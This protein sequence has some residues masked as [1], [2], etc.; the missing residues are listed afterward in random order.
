MKAAPPF[1][2][3]T[4]MLVED[5]VTNNLV[6]WNDCGTAFIVWRPAEFAR[7]LLPTLFKH[8]NFSSFV[9][10]LNTYFD[11]LELHFDSLKFELVNIDKRDETNSSSNSAKL[12]GFRKVA[13]SRWE[14]S[15]E[16]F[17]KGERNQ[18]CN[19]RRR[20]SFS[21]KPRPNT[22]AQSTHEPKTQSSVDRSTSSTSS[23]SGFTTLAD[24]NKRLKQEN[25]VLRNELEIMKRKSK[26][27]FDL[28]A[29]YNI[30]DIEREAH[31]HMVNREKREGPKLFGVSLLEVEA[32]MEENYKIG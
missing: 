18:L 9:R 6:S 26:E 3:K 8:C 11:Y 22:K 13:T 2:V 28:V 4:Y 7:D 1:L 5:P 15:N 12:V 27:L 14:F 21:N 19:I 23:S 20:K 31:K 16:M 17:R 30:G 24:E 32:K 10:Q 25:G 29:I